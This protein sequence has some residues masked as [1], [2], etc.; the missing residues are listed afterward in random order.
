MQRWKVLLIK[1]KGGDITTVPAESAEAAIEKVTKDHKMSAAD[2]SMPYRQVR[3]KPTSRLSAKDLSEGGFDGR[4]DNA[5]V[6]IP[7]PS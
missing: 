4:G 7:T 2:G 5:V 1:R 6:G 3:R